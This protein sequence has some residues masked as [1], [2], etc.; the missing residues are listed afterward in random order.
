MV[1]FYVVYQPRA[2]ACDGSNDSL[3]PVD[4]PNVATSCWAERCTVDL[5]TCQSGTPVILQESEQYSMIWSAL[6]KVT[7][8]ERQLVQ[9]ESGFS[10]FSVWWSL[11]FSP[12]F[13]FPPL[14]C[15]PLTLTPQVWNTLW[16][17]EISIFY[18]AWNWSCRQ[19][20][21][22]FTANVAF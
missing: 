15:L 6:R 11:V 12:L 19:G 16:V 3:F 5:L 17:L 14:R 22:H 9:Q 8:L 7:V 2:H 1:I 13:S 10:A 4:Y 21:L 18:C 20:S